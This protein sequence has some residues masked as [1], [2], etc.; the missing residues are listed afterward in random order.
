M[1]QNNSHWFYEPVKKLDGDAL[2]K[3]EAH[4]ASLTKP[5]GSLGE[6]ENIAIKFAAWQGRVK[7]ELDRIGICVFAADHGICAKGISA[8]PQAVTVQMVANFVA[9]G[10]AISVLAK[11]LNADFSV[12]NTGVAHPLLADDGVINAAVAAGTADFSEA[13][14][15]SP[16]QCLQALNTGKKQVVD[17][18]WQL[19][20]GGE[21]GIGNTTSATALYCALLGLSS[22]KAAGPGTGI[23]SQGITLK[24]QLINDA[25]ER[26]VNKGTTALQVLQ[27]MGGF[28]IAALVGAYIACAQ[29]GIPV[30]VD[31]FICTA[32]ALI[33][34]KLNP[35]V[36]KWMLFAHKSAEPAHI[37]AL[38]Y[39]NVRPLLDL[40]MRLGEGSGAAVAL[41]IVKSAL[42]LHNHMATFTQANVSNGSS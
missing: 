42:Q 35:D 34:I 31:G 13:A 38:D 12:V 16:E 32:A 11:A 20:I 18:D 25:L 24:A 14:A 6:L 21:M 33:A 17:T 2:K 26:H 22:R 15:M 28:E 4:Q 19:F 8:F 23:S 40:S 3:A 30:L 10:A 1:Q 41:P 36:Q 39:L 29:Q 9:G 5:P 27:T 37:Q 7:P